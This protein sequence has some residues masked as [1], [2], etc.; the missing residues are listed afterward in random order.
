[1]T[2]RRVLVAGVGNIFF[3]DDGFG[4]EVANRLAGS[5][6]PEGVR[7]AEYGIRGLHLAYD[8][9]DDVDVLVL[10][11]ALPLGEQPGVVALVEAEVPEPPGPDDAPPDGDPEPTVDAH[12]MSPAVVLSSL[13]SLGGTLDRVLVVGCQP[14]SVAEG[15]G[16]TPVVAEAVDRAVAMVHEVVADITQ[17]ATRESP[18]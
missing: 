1:M 17:P 2:A 16:L 5:P 6:L 3:S 4:V 18:A 11:D 13:A 9:V 15:I 12:S 10:I 7:L 8:L 14:E